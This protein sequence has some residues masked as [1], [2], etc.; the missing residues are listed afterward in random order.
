MTG[1]TQVVRCV[2]EQGRFGLVALLAFLPPALQR[3]AARLACLSRAELDTFNNP[4]GPMPKI[5]FFQ[6]GPCGYCW[7]A[8]THLLPT[9]AP[10]ADDCAC[11]C[12]PT[13]VHRRHNAPGMLRRRDMFLEPDG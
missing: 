2:A 13:C 3:V 4:L 1:V 8:H 9:R 10:C 11:V 6:V 7:S 12:M 5:E